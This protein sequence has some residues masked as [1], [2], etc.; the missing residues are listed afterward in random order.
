MESLARAFAGV[1]LAASV[2]QTTPLPATWALA[3]GAPRVDA[4]MIATTLPG[5]RVALDLVE[6]NP[7][8]HAPIRAYDIDMTKV[9]HLVVISADFSQFMH[10]HPTFDAATGHFTQTLQLDPARG[11]Y[12]YADTEPTGIGQ[13]VFRFT[14][15]GNVR[16][17]HGTLETQRLTVASGPYSISI[18]RGTLKA[19]APQ[20]LDVTILQG[21]H[22]ATNLQPYLGAAAH[23][24]FINMASLNYV[25]VHPTLPG[26]SDDMDMDSMPMAAAAKAGPRMT[27][28]V[29]PLA[30]GTYKLWLEFRGGSR[31]LVAPFTLVAR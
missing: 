25:H 11:Y 10:L 15:P 7:T 14:V 29:P 3:N 28:H 19:S 16:G 5:N 6:T 21:G 27:L 31:L 22:P 13:Q 20:T 1:V 24:V 23:A 18:S 8:T 17:Y 12:I 30:T 9:I 26:Q 2:A 4:R